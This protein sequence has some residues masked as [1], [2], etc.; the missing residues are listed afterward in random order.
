MKAET[1][2]IDPDHITIGALMKACFNAGQ[3]CGFFSFC[4]FS[5]CSL[6]LWLRIS[7]LQVE[8]AKEVY[9]MIHKYGIKGT[10]EVYT[11]AVNN[12]SK[13]GD[14]DFACSIYNDMKEKGVT[15]DEVCLFE[16][17][18]LLEVADLYDA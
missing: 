14:W 2:P 9:K 15:P 4:S 12:C 7:L 17:Y 13:S 6:S 5:C 8:R 3:V 1:H 18:I 16:F 10:P 11:I